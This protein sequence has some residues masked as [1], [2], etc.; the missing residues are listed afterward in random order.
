MG[1]ETLKIKK[2][3]SDREIKFRLWSKEDF[4]FIEWEFYISLNWNLYENQH[5]HIVLLPKDKYVIVQYTGLKDKNWKEIYEWD[6]LIDK[7]KTW[8]DLIPRVVEFV[9]CNVTNWWHAPYVTQHWAHWYSSVKLN[10]V[11]DKVEIIWNIYEN[12]ELLSE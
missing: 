11:F 4:R 9:S 1:D 5:W 3:W 8:I 7:T 10:L 12:P 2:D 6:L